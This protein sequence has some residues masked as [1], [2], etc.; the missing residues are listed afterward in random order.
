[1]R[2]THKP[3]IE[4]VDGLERQLTSELRRQQRFSPAERSTGSKRLM[5]TAILFIACAATGVAAAKTVEHIESSKRRI[6]HVARIEAATEQLQARQSVVQGMVN[7]LKD[8]VDAGLIHEDELV[9]AA[10]QSMLLDLDMEK[11]LLDLEEVHMSG[12]APAN[13]LYAPLQGGRD[14]VTERLLI[15]YRKIELIRDQIVERAAAVRKRA[16]AGLVP[17]KEIEE[18]DRQIDR[19]NGELDEIERRIDLRKGYLSGDLSARE[20]SLRQMKESARSRLA[21]A[22][23]VFQVVESQH[24]EMSKLYADGLIPERDLRD[25]EYAIIEARSECRIA[26]IELELLEERLEE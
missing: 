19:V 21:E 13:E 18:Q 5:K 24:K 22:E 3:D 10:I 11:A 12:E 16:D 14:F 25:A 26:E 9:E 6:L 2:N 8:R 15:D 7:E 17:R 23:R 1:M 20:I 4:F